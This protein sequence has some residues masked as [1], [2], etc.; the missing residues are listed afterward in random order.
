[1]M[2]VCVLVLCSTFCGV[3]Q[4]ANGETFSTVL[5]TLFSLEIPESA[6]QRFLL[7]RSQLEAK[8]C[9]SRRQLLKK[10]KSTCHA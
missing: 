5:V 1:M 3:V 8:I 10:K 2:G 4:S 6:H 7:Q 9:R